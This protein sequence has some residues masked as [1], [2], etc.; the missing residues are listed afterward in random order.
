MA[1]GSDPPIVIHGGSVT[2]EFPETN[3]PPDPSRNGKFKNDNKKI[4]R[5]EITGTGIENYDK[6]ATGKDITV[7]VFYD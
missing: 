2:I 7:R 4:S 3:F 1:N 6:A 5:V